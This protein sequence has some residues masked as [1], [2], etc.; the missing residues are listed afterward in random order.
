MFQQRF[1]L[2]DGAA[3]QHEFQ[4][5]PER[6]DPAEDFLQDGFERGVA[7][8]QVREFVD[9]DAQASQVLRGLGE[10]QQQRA[11]GGRVLDTPAG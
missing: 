2:A 10:A 8:G 9:D 6:F 4:G 11:P 7:A 5:L 1:H 3:A